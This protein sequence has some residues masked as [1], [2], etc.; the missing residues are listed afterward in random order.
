MYVPNVSSVFLDVCCK[1]VYLNVAYVLHIICLQIFYLGFAYV[2][3]MVSSVFQVFLS[4]SDACF[5]CFIVFKRML[6]ALIWM[7]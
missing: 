3:A 1:C 6:Q 5:K 2:F 7:F 4:V